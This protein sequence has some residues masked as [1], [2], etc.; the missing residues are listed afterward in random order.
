MK[1]I[2]LRPACPSDIDAIERFHRKQNERDGTDYP[3]TRI[4]NA[5][6]S[7]SRNVPVA[8]VGDRGGEPM[9]ALYVERTAELMF[10]GCDPKATAFARRD[11]DALC[12][13]LAWQGYTGL[14]CAVPVA[15]AKAIA[16]P[17]K[18]AGFERTD[19]RLAH[20]FRD[21]REVTR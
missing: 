17:L 7:L 2:I 11:A 16:K 5:D 9:Q 1:P 10:A 8:L 4:F 20:F 19:D 14:H 3:L 15:L 12:A 21:L 6:G 13:V 18:A